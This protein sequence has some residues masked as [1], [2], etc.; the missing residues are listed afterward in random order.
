MDN[1][2]RIYTVTNSTDTFIKIAKHPLMDKQRGLLWGI[3]DAL[4]HISNGDYVSFVAEVTNNKLVIKNYI[5]ESVDELLTWVH[6]DTAIR[7]TPTEFIE[8]LNEPGL[9]E[10]NTHD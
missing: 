5:L 8:A 3:E 9:E 10:L 4:K 1:N 2:K 6:P 7:V